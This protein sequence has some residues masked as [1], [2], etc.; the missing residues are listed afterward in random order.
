MLLLS[1]D[2]LIMDIREFFRWDSDPGSV[3]PTLDK[4]HKCGSRGFVWDIKVFI[5]FLLSRRVGLV[6][7]HWL[8]VLVVVFCLGV[9]LGVHLG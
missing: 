6:V 8:L 1:G 3:D 7:W 4:K 5:W 2:V 9:F